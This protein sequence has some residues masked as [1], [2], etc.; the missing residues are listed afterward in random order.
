MAINSNQCNTNT[1]DESNSKVFTSKI[2][3][4]KH[5]QSERYI[6][7][8]TNSFVY[9]TIFNNN[10]VTDIGQQIIVILL[11]YYRN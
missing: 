10:S 4:K 7:D 6:P 9:S 1:I 8:R 11:T 2:A 3:G 5:F